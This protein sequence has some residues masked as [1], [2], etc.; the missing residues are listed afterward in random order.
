M[1]LRDMAVRDVSIPRFHRMLLSASDREARKMRLLLATSWPSP[2][3]CSECYRWLIYQRDQLT[4]FFLLTNDYHSRHVQGETTA[5]ETVAGKLR[6]A[7]AAGDAGGD[8]GCFCHII[9]SRR[10]LTVLEYEEQRRRGATAVQKLGPKHRD[11]SW[12][13]RRRYM[14]CTI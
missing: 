8:G 1:R 14:L 7:D 6:A 10:A 3:V 13:R 11:P 5:A 12:L 9:H 2:R 4:R